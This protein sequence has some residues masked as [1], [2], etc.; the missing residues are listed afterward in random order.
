[1][2]LG[3]HPPREKNIGIILV[4]A[5]PD[6]K[7]KSCLREEGLSQAPATMGRKEQE[8]KAKRAAELAAGAPPCQAATPEPRFRIQSTCLRKWR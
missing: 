5:A 8:K 2:P 4:Q 6:S 1:M 3:S 7:V